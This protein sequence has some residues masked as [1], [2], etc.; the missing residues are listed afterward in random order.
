MSW[1]VLMRGAHAA[2]SPSRGEPATE[3]WWQAKHTLSY[4][5][6]PSAAAGFAAAAL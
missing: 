3:T 4:T 2:L 1:P 5:A 6:L